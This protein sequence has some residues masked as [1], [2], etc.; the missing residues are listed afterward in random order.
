MT[1]TYLV[2]CPNCDKIQNYDIYDLIEPGDTDGTF[3]L[4]CDNCNK[5]F[6]VE[7]EFKPYV[8]TY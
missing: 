6:D 8:E 5:K 4:I 2:E 7:F 1:Q 3:P